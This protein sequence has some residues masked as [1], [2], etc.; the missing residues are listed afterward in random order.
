MK[1]GLFVARSTVHLLINFMTAS[2]AESQVREILAIVDSSRDVPAGTLRS[3]VEAS[4]SDLRV[5]AGTSL[6]LSTMAKISRTCDSA[7]EAVMKLIRRCTVLRATKSPNFMQQC[8]S[9]RNHT[10]SSQGEQF[11]QVFVATRCRYKRTDTT[12]IQPKDIQHQRIQP[13]IS[14]TARISK[15]TT[16]SDWRENWARYHAQTKKLR[17]CFREK[18]Q[19]LTKFGSTVPCPC[20]RGA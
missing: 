11:N 5:P 6:E 20:L 17:T 3:E 2:N 9:Q 18:T 8:P 12:K 16:P 19:C 13:K 10:S 7:F 14:N 4:T 15:A 1:F